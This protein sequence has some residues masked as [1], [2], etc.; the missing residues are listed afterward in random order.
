METLLFKTNINCNGCIAKAATV[1]NNEPAI[2]TWEVDTTSPDK[3][4]TVETDVLN[5][6]QVMQIVRKAGFVAEP[7]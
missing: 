4:L 3:L 5:T 1:L 6:P 7:A 2:I